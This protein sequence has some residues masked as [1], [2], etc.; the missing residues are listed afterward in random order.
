M[1]TLRMLCSGLA[2]AVA[3]TATQQALKATVPDAPR[4][5]VLGMRG[6]RKV[7]ESLHVPVP[8]GRDLFNSALVGDLICNSLYYSPVGKKKGIS[9]L[10]SG[11]S[12]GLMAGIGA[13]KL[14]QQLGL[15]KEERDP[16]KMAL[17]M[18]IY[19]AGGLAA[20]LAAN[21]IPGEKAA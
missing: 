19:V 16:K 14:P 17:T 10:G 11:L 9:A 5:D 6:I 20:A 21:A 4:M 12:L 18:A 3:A 7:L 2:G 15:G 13:L 1:N 8:N